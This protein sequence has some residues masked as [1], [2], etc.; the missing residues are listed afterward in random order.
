M[1]AR[2][3]SPHS[4]Y[5][6]ASARPAQC[7]CQ[8][9]L[10]AVLLAWLLGQLPPTAQAGRALRASYLK[11]HQWHNPRFGGGRGAAHLRLSP[12]APVSKG[13]LPDPVPDVAADLLIPEHLL[14][15]PRRQDP[16]QNCIT[17]QH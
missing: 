1:A 2:A 7:H 3:A 9:L 8:Q 17:F 10:L 13:P 14:Q 11:S 6:L 5:R 16:L 12:G 4:R 15:E